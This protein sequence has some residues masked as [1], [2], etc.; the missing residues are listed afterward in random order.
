MIPSRNLPPAN[1]PQNDAEHKSSQMLLFTALYSARPYFVRGVQVLSCSPLKGILCNSIANPSRCVFCVQQYR[2]WYVLMSA[3][4]D[5]FGVTF[6][7]VQQYR[8]RSVSI[9]ALCGGLSYFLLGTPLTKVIFRIGY[10]PNK[11]HAFIW[12]ATNNSYIL[13]W[14]RP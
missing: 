6:S 5:G 14:V 9:S 8:S 7:S 12:H 13:Y 2:N 3:L 4:C 11:S 10:A 1:A